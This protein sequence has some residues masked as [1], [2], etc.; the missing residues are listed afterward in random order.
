MLT[1]INKCGCLLADISGWNPNVTFELGYAYGKNKLCIQLANEKNYKNPGNLKGTGTIAY[2][3]D[4]PGWPDSFVDG[5]L[6]TEAIKGF[7]QIYNKD[8]QSLRVSLKD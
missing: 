8:K 1:M 3:S 4:E 6:A 7:K 2:N 5:W